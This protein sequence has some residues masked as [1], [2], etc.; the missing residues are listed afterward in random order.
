MTI[1]NP[2]NRYW[3]QSA[4]VRVMDLRRGH[5][6]HS[7]KYDWFLSLYDDVSRNE[8]LIPEPVLQRLLDTGVIEPVDSRDGPASES[9]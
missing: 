7:Q 4:G 6:E 1:V 2:F 8:I 5:P 3:G 9:D